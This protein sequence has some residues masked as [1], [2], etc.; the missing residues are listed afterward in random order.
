MLPRIISIL[1]IE[2]YTIT[3]LWTTNETRTIDFIKL[4]ERLK[5][6]Y[7]DRILNVSIFGQAKLN[8]NTKT[9][10]WE[11]ILSGKNEKGE[12]ITGDLDICPDTLYQN[13]NPI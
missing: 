11:G 7:L 6:N 3:C 12:H 1:H 9:L 13:S 4:K 5:G 2:P 10:Y 8:R